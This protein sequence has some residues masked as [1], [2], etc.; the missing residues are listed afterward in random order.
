MAL[1]VAIQVYSVRDDAAKDLYST[2][3]SIKEMGYDGVELNYEHFIKHHT[4]A[5][6][7]AALDE[8][9]LPCYS[10]MLMLE[11][12]TPDKRESTL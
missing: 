2:L 5:E 1:P 10:M 11:A 9:G 6:L 4:A 12:L 3:K 8:A 7:K